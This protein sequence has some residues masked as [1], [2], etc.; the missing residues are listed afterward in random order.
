M[1]GVIACCLGA[2]AVAGCARG[3]RDELARQ[4][5]AANC[6]ACHTVPGVGTARGKVG[7]SLAG[8][9]SRQVIAGR[10]PNSRANMLHWITHAQSVEPGSVMP[11]IPLTPA[12]AGAVA[13]YLYSLD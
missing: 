1:R 4:T 5:I 3:A 11:D 9:G 10:L 12:Q 7:P 8:I 2:L 13:D 6:G